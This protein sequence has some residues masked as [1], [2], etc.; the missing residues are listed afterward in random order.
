MENKTVDI[1]KL[2]RKFKK[3]SADRQINRREKEYFKKKST[4]R[5]EKKIEIRRTIEKNNK[6]QASLEAKY[7]SHN[8]FR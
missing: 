1:D 6:K 2:I 7:N 3:E 8:R 4:I 5:H